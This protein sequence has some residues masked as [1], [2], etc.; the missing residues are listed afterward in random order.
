MPH[1]RRG[2]TGHCHCE[3]MPCVERERERVEVLLILEGLGNDVLVGVVGLIRV[4]IAIADREAQ[5]QGKFPPKTI[6]NVLGFRSLGHGGGLRLDF[7][8]GLVS[9]KSVRLV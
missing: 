4:P 9:G 7:R 8:L 1:T 5:H 2:A 6:C 3:A